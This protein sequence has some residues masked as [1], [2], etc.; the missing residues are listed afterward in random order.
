MEALRLVLRHAC[1]MSPAMSSQYTKHSARKMLV[2]TAQD[3]GCPWEQCIKLGHWKG[4]SLDNKCLLPTKTV[5]RK[6]AL[7]SMPMPTRYAAN[8]RIVR[9]A[10]IITNQVH[11]LGAYLRLPVAPHAPIQQGYRRFI[12]YINRTNERMG[13]LFWK[14][15]PMGV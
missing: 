2:S 8:A 4:T 10:R 15:E 11:C 5:R 14:S 12:T 3:G 13:D 1:S 6:K 9:V 7:A